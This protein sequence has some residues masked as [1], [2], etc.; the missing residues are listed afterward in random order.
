MH[1]RAFLQGA[2]ALGLGAAASGPALGQSFPSSVI[3]TVVPYS[4]STPPDI[5]ARI[6]TN[7]LV[8]GEGWK[9]IVENKPGA[10]MTIGANEVLKQVADGHTLLSI[11]API[12]A[13]PALM[14]N[15]S[16][17]IENDFAP[18]I[19]VATGYNILVV[20]PQVPV[21][22]VPELIVY[23]KKNPGKHTFSSG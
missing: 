16:F 4:A 14:P 15:A 1:R 7:A 17:N 22:S 13:V 9:M 18:V 21:H 2:A 19:H 23:L 11:T 10:V 20:N 12:A 3:R 6:V 8:A 5:I